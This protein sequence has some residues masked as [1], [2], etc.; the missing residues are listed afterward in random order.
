MMTGRLNL[1]GFKFDFLSQLLTLTDFTL[2]VF[3]P[4]K[5]ASDED[6]HTSC[7]KSLKCPF[8]DK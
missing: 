5:T 3:R 8:I 6:L 2:T 7:V 4:Y 1:K